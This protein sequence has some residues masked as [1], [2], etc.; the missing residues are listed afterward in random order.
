MSWTNEQIK[1]AEKLLNYEYLTQTEDTWEEGPYD[2]VKLALATLTIPGVDM[3]GLAPNVYGMVIL[4][5]A[6]YAELRRLWG[7]VPDYVLQ[8]LYKLEFGEEDEEW[9]A[10]YEE[11]KVKYGKQV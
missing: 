2:A 8:E 7:V 10:W 9:K 1:E 4:I 11:D 5:L 3:R 6:K